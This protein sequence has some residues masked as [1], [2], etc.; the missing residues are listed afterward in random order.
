MAYI[1]S[2]PAVPTPLLKQLAKTVG[3]HAIRGLGDEIFRL[4]GG[5]P[6]AADAAREQAGNAQTDCLWV[7]EARRPDDFGLLVMDMDSTLITI[8][9]IDEIADLAGLKPRVAEITAAAMRGE[10]DFAQSLRQR[11]K[12]LAG[13]PESVLETVYTQ[14]LK[15]TPGGEIML[16]RL[17]AA[18]LRSLLISGGFTYF[19]QRL[20]AR[21]G[22]TASVANS[23]EIHQGKLTGE[24]LGEIVDAQAKADHL[25]SLR[26][27]LGLRPEQVVAIGDGA[28]DLRMLAAA[29]LSVAFHAKP[30]LQA[31]ASHAIN[32][33]NLDTLS[34]LLGADAPYAS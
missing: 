33:G 30:V 15:I 14:R 18:G 22:L 10:L 12:L 24:V 2:G 19:T 21:L 5:Q 20:Q 8:E 32:H 11:V 23:L 3:A 25:Q 4:E 31:Q 26:E 9:C 6:E 13:L 34:A 17:H 27:H 7:P 28:N 16:R 1:V 29:G